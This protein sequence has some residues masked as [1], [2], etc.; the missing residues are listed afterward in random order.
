M[1]KPDVMAITEA[2]A[3]SNHL[4]SELLLP[5]YEIFQINRM[6]KKVGGVICYVKSTL[7]ALKFEKQEAENYDSST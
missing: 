4:V 1:E 6:N 3:K 7:V 2:W 5:G